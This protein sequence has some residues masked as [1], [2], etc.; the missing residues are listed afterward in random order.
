MS[1]QSMLRAARRTLYSLLLLLG[2]SLFSFV[3][4]TIAPG[5][6]FDELRLN[7][8][9][10]AQTIAG[11]KAQY[12]MGRPL[13]VRY[14]LWLAALAK[15]EMGYSLEYRRPV[16]SLL[17]PRAKNTLLLTGMATLLA[18]AVALIWGILLAI[19]GGTWLDRI[20]AAPV[21]LL[22]A[23]PDVLLG[24]LLLLLA[25][26]TG[27]LP[28]GGMQSLRSDRPAWGGVELLSHMILPVAALTL[29]ALPILVRHVR[30]AM[31][32]ALGAPFVRA[33][34][35]HGIGSA[36]MVFRYALP[37]AMNSLISLFGFSVGGLLSMSLLIEVVLGWPGLGPLVLEAMLA[38]DIYVVMAV[39]MLSSLFLVFGNL[40]A[41][42]LLY[43]NDPRIRTESA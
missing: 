8:Q 32:L 39:V 38:R 37:A 27:W 3:L 25:A 41:D 9:I 35:A 22:L 17:W 42:T 34:E 6:F 7:P 13:P 43:W 15:G 4:L 40:L 30:T 28:A 16:G 29:G 21:A 33:S 5:N 12:G 31:A 2:V 10:S 1:K 19:R 18:W 11:F 20:A 26:K 24:L 23:I 14:G 36:R